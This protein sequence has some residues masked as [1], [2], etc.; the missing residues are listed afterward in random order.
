MRRSQHPGMTRYRI[1][2]V[3]NVEML[4]LLPLS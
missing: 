1:T 2:T 3:N 4:D